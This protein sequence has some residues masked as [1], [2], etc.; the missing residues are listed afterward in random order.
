MN[1][2]HLEDELK[3]IEPNEKYSLIWKDINYEIAEYS[4]FSGLPKLN[5]SILNN[6]N[7]Y[8]QSGELTAIMGPSG[9][10]KSSLLDYLKNIIDYPKDS[11]HSGK[12]FLN[13]Y[14]MTNEDF[15]DQISYVTQYSIKNSVFT[16]KEI[17]MSVAELRYTDTKDNIENIVNY[18]IQGMQLEKCTDT[19]FGDDQNIGLSG[20]EKKRVC[21]GAKILMDFPILLLDE[22]TSGL[23][24][25]TSFTIINFL[26]EYAIKYNKIILSTIHQPSSN[27]F[28]LF[29]KVIILNHGRVLYHGP[30]GNEISKYFNSK[31]FSMKE[32]YNPSDSFMRILEN[33]NHNYY[34]DYKDYANFSNAINDSKCNRYNLK[35]Y[36]VDEYA[37]EKE[38]EV[39]NEIDNYLIYRH[40]IVPKV[41]INTSCIKEFKIILRDY[42]RTVMRNPQILRIKF[43]TILFFV[44]MCGSI[45]FKLENNLEGNRGKLGFMLFFTVSNL[46][47]QI[48]NVVMLFP[49]D[50]Y[51][52]KDDYNSNLYGVIPY[53]LARQ[54]VD[55]P[56]SQLITILY[57]TLVY[58]MIGFKITIINFFTLVG[59]YAAFIFNVESIGIL[60]GCFI[61][62]TDAGFK[63]MS[64]GV[65]ILF[66]F[67]GLI[68]N[69]SNMPIWL[70]WI[71]YCDPIFY[72]IQ[73]VAINEFEGRN[74]EG[75]NVYVNI[76]ENF[77]IW[78]CVVYLVG[79]GVCLRLFSFIG[80]YLAVK[81][82]I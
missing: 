25:S 15:R 62:S 4:E 42:F 2:N 14:E 53:S 71:R 80:L 17:L 16:T 34:Y 82:I 3:E 19:I 10:G 31:G 23:D 30:G 22:P 73:S 33:L 79:V 7:G 66:I 77:D 8:C 28:N 24:S 6:I 45:F 43:F 48:I 57:C 32:N 69:A 65:I 59:I 58:F 11:T 38:I 41:I 37:K 35:N 20:G 40:N 56:F 18:I 9:A 5:K 27:I 70:S 13:G 44:F 75:V 68:I 74:F 21:V 50:K 47:Q 46:M 63:V 60:F 76:K 78:N 1:S 61:T 55:T 67:S 26:R 51:L 81:R 12:I 64:L 39:V 29:D 49:K 52:L 54:F 72:C 36:F